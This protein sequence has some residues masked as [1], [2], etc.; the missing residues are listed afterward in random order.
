M[1]G[2][3]LFVVAF[4][5]C[6]CRASSVVIIEVIV[7][8]VVTKS[9][10]S[11]RYSGTSRP[12]RVREMRFPKAGGIHHWPAVGS[13]NPLKIHSNAESVELP[14]NGFAENFRAK[15]DEGVASP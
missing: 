15:R 4:L 2:L 3:S 5:Y 14:I 11:S 1:V 10:I 8:K 7:N 12:I 9:I 6:R 13:V